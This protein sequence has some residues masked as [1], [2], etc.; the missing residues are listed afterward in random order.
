MNGYPYEF[1]SGIE[2]SKGL[3][4]EIIS[5][6]RIIVSSRRNCLGENN[7]LFFS[8]SVSTVSHLPL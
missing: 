6:R 7:D 3:G 2:E 1:M 4:Q 8:L 5:N